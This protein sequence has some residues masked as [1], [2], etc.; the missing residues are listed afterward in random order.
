MLENFIKFVHIIAAMVFFGLPFTFG[1]WYG[2]SVAGGSMGQVATTVK[3]IKTFVLVHLTSS[4]LVVMGTGIYLAFAR[5]WWQGARWPHWALLLMLLSLV[6]LHFVLRP[7]LSR[8]HGVE[9]TGHPLIGKTRIRIAVFSATHHTLV[10]LITLLMV[11]RD[12]F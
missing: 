9:E 6:N 1:R 11:F 3:K 7:A 4:A 12:T 2:S 8:L 5:G 10:T